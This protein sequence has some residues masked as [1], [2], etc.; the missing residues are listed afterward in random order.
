MAKLKPLQI[1]QSNMFTAFDSIEDLHIFMK[2]YAGSENYFI[3]SLAIALTINTIGNI[4]EKECGGK[5]V[6]LKTESMIKKEV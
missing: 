6:S 3:A 2:N 5:A 1:Q 4:M